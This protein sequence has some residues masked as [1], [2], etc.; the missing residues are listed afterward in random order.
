MISGAQDLTRDS[1]QINLDRLIL[2]DSGIKHGDTLYIRYTSGDGLIEGV[3]G[4]DV[5]SFDSPFTVL[6]SGPVL[7][8]DKTLFSAISEDAYIAFRG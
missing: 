4:S 6:F 1:I 2:E 3:D 5:A 7:T 8:G